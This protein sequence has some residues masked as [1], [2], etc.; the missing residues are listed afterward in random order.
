[1]N[2]AIKDPPTGFRWVFCR[3]RKVR[4]S[5]GRVLDAHD[6]GYQAWRFLVHC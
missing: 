4:G 5:S 1:M 6:Y 3:F 2:N